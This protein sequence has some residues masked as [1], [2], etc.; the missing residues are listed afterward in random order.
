[1]VLN[2]LCLLLLELVAFLTHDVS[3]QLVARALFRDDE[4]E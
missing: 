4:V 1:M 2:E 3:E